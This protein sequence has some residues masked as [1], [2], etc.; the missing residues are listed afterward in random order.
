ML[1]KARGCATR[2]VA[3]QIRAPTSDATSSVFI[4]TWG[5]IPYEL[6]VFCK[7]YLKPTCLV[8]GRGSSVCIILG[9]V[10]GGGARRLRRRGGEGGVGGDAGAGEGGEGLRDAGGGE[11]D[12][13][14]HERR[15]GEPSS[16]FIFRRRLYLRGPV[17]LN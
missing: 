7:E 16:V 9:L 3:T 1:Q 8:L 2:A 17:C 15:D 6:A 5:P 11:A 13:R 10:G 12:P 14:S 4:Y